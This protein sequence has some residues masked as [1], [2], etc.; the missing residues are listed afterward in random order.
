MA[1]TSRG[2]PFGRRAAAQAVA[3]LALGA[4]LPARAQA[5]T[6]FPLRVAAG[7]R[8]LEDRNGRPFLLHGDTAWSLIAQ[9]RLEEA[10]AYL[11]DRRAR[12]FNAILVNLI[13][14]KFADRAPAN[15]YGDRPF[16]GGDDF[17]TPNEAYFAHA[18]RV[19][20]RAA[21]LGFLTLLTPAYLGY[22]GNDE[23]WYQA[24][25]AAGDARLRGYAEFVG[26]RYGGLRNIMWV[27]GGDYDP[28]RRAPVHAIAE[29][30][31]RFDRT[32]L[33]TA[34]CAPETATAAFWHDAP[35]IDVDNIYT[36][37]P[38]HLAARRAEAR[39]PR[40]PFFL[41]ES[42]YENEH[43]VSEERLRTQAY[44]AL[45]GGACGQVFGNNPIWHF[46][47]RGARE[48]PVTWRQ[49]LGGGGSRG[50]EHVARL[51]AALP[52]W[53][54]EPDVGGVLLA[55]QPEEGGAHVSG[56]VATDRRLALVHV[57]ATVPFRVAT[58][59]MRGPGWIA[60][61]YDPASG[62]YRQ[63]PEEALDS[64]L[65]HPPGRNAG[66]ATDWVLEIRAD[67]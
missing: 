34:H 54:L 31:R 20:R 49:A 33:H 41:I 6:A 17:A 10:E 8:H 39:S 46:G 47:T 14:R 62:R 53:L 19:L 35:W 3:G 67:G 52:W 7:R 29:G 65:F 26:R 61:W 12:G 5:G 25:L 56:A 37:Q 11:Q 32:A 16:R 48:A 44:Q 38:V 60:R 63:A 64:G 43:G 36:Y 55:A 28:P 59:R 58:A 22:G 66:G 13:E 50:M 57:P 4:A 9:L 2:A 27:H 42:T 51:F 21:E 24:M 15:V 18:D 23:G 40:R 30:I 45:L 1:G